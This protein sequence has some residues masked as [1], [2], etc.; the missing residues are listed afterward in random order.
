[1]RSLFVLLLLLGLAAP[2]AQAQDGLRISA[3]EIG[4]RYE[5][6]S[7]PFSDGKGVYARAVLAGLGG[8][9]RMESD[10]IDRFGDSG[11]I[12]GVGHTRTL[13][14]R[15]FVSGYVGSS[16]TGDYL[17]RFRVGAE[18]ARKWGPTQGVVTSAGLWMIDARDVHRDMQATAEVSVY[19]KNAILQLGTRGTLSTPGDA[20]GYAAHAALTLGAPDGRSIT[21]RLSFGREAYLLVEPFTADVEFHSGEASLMIQQPLTDTWQLQLRAGHYRNPYYGRTGIEGGIRYRFGP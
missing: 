19:A 12:Y 8:T 17:P 15:V 16:T 13:S 1:M 7:G 6:I 11:V 2:C 5:S 10:A 9:W 4:T 21:G 14:P 3:L 20:L 18:V